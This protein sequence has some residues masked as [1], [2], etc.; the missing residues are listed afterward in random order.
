MGAKSNTEKY[1]TSA[2]RGDSNDMPVSAVPGV[3]SAALCG[4]GIFL[5]NKVSQHDTV[6]IATNGKGD[7]TQFHHTPRWIVH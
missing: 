1:A 4:C 2:L 6:R 7:D 5:D 3:N